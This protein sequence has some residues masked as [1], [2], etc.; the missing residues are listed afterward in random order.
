MAAP[1]AQAYVPD[2]HDLT[3]LAEAAQ[4]CEGCDLYLDAE[5]TVFGSGT[6]EARIMFIGEQPGDREDRAGL[7]FVGPAGKMF[8]KALDAAGIS[9]GTTYVT[10]A[11]KHFKFTRSER[12]KQRIHKKPGRTEIVAC[13]P[14]LVSELESVQPDVVVCLGATAAQAILGK[15]F[16]LTA[17]RGEVFDLSADGDLPGLSISPQVTATIHPSA[18]LRGPPE[19]R[20]ATFAAFV[21]DLRNAGQLID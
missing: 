10:N 2:T 7:P 9:R 3:R 8:D 15:T 5:Q 16:R 12:G 14:W 6:D 21:E 13:R 18:I 17:H 11:V 4:H 20:D 19:D 1:G